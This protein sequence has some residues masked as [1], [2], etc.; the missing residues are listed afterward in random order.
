MYV[1]HIDAA[2]NAIVVG[3]EEELYSREASVSNVNYTLGHQP[4]EPVTVTVKL[5]YKAPP[6]NAILHPYGERAL[7][8]FDEPQRAITP[9]QAA[10]FYQDNEVLG[11]GRIDDA[12]PL[13]SSEHE[14]PQSM[15]I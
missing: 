8:R 6:A 9:G 10:V 7:L 15:G 5:R 12:P 1:T 11:G 2:H 4:A 13:Q 14:L 3:P